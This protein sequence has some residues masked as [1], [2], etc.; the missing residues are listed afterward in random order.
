MSSKLQV[1][2][3][4]DRELVMTRSFAAPRELVFQAYTRPELVRRWLGA[5]GGWTMEVCEIDLRPGGLYRYLWRGPA[6]ETMGMRGEYREVVEPERIVNTERFDESWYPGGAVG[7][8]VFEQRGESTLLTTTVL[9]D[10]KEARDG[11]LASPME[12]GVEASYAAL[13]TVLKQMPPIP[14]Q[15]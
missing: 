10:T 15:S 9:Y 3:N 14:A 13:E 2:A 1:T 7:T 5:M 4:G 6:G 11:V 8:A 12:S